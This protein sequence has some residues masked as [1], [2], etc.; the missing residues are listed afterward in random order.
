MTLPT[1]AAVIKTIAPR[2]KTED[3]GKI[4]EQAICLA[5]GILYDGT[6]KYDMEAPTVLKDR[7]ARLPE[8]FPLCRHTAKR[9]AR[10]DF[11]A[12]GDESLHLSAKTTKKGVGKVAPQVIGQ[13]QPKNFCE[14]LG[15]P[16][17]NVADLKHHIQTNITSILPV[18]VSH[19]FDCPNL[20]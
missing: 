17:T 14:I 4:F 11:T 9:G 20:F 7:L 2:V 13:T 3:T 1:A 19:T 12:V 16:Y 18:L 10:Y 6:Y 8:L 15:I 5:Y